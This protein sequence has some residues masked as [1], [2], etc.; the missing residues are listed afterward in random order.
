MVLTIATRDAPVPITLPSGVTAWALTT[1]EDGMRTQVRGLA[2]A[3]ADVVVEKIAPA[4]SLSAALG[5]LTAGPSL[6]RAFSPP[7]PD[8][9]I[10]CGRRSAPYAVAMKR[11]S[12]GRM[13]TV[14]VQDPRAFRTEFDLIIAMDHD[15]IDEGPGVI[16]VATALH[17]IT[18]AAL[19][20]AAEGWRLRF[21]RLGRP[22][23]GVAIGGDLRG[24]PFSLD[25]GRRLLD[26]LQ[27]L[28]HAGLGLA[29][30]PSRRT[31][32][33]VR[34]LLAE[35]FAGDNRVFLW[36]LEGDN[37]YRAILALA[38]RLVVTTDSVSMVS[39]AI[40]TD[41]PVELYDLGFRRHIGFVQELVDMGLARRFEGDPSPFSTRGPFDSTQ[42]AAAAVRRLLQARTGIVG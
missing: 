36:D 31:P 38:D 37:P 6:A 39:E 41:H 16:K 40:A 8:I 32:L 7:W 22:L 21:E 5:A 29:I 15:R 10:T 4:R 34:A 12:G 33:P 13:L 27:R 3:V 25:D 23:A 30:T 20:A 19:A 24:R 9:L 11:A 42:V 18:P 1:G 28:R 14:H 35:A 26:G 2:Q 17:D